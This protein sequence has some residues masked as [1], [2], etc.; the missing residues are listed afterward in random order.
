MTGIPLKTNGQNRGVGLVIEEKDWERIVDQIKSLSGNNER[1][2]EDTIVAF[3]LSDINIGHFIV[4]EI[5][6]KW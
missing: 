1:I 3:L 2:D 5:L 4:D 6:G